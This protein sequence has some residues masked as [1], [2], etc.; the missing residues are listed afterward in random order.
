MWKDL[1]AQKL[2][3]SCTIVLPSFLSFHVRQRKVLTLPGQVHSDQRVATWVIIDNER[4]NFAVHGGDES[5][6]LTPG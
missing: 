2:L 1:F 6:T 5:L 3:P 4:E